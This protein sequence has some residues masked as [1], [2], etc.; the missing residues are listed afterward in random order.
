MAMQPHQEQEAMQVS[1]LQCNG[2]CKQAES[3]AC[4]LPAE[5]WTRPIISDPMDG[6]AADSLS[7]LAVQVQQE[8]V[9]VRSPFEPYYPFGM[10]G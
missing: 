7:G 8:A 5:C 6:H 3:Q 10:T 4:M 9:Q 1:R 2:L